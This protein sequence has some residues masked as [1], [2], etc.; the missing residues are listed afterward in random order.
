MAGPT[1]V[2]AGTDDYDVAAAVREAGCE[3][4]RV[5]VA[6]RPALEDAGVVSAEAFL[7]TEVAQATSIA[8]AKDLNPDLTVVVYA[9]GSLPDFV[10][11][12]ADLILDPALFEPESV[13]ES[14][15]D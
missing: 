4:S 15:S 11:G 5:D 10:R 2:V 1:V 7:L 13:A 12:Q 8:V 9:D 3:L 14:I 6:N